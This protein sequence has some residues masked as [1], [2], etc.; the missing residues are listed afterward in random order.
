MESLNATCPR[1]TVS[2]ISMIH[3]HKLESD[4]IHLTLPYRRL[5]LFF[6][7][8]NTW[9]QIYRLQLNCEFEVPKD[10][11]HYIENFII[12]SYKTLKVSKL[13]SPQINL[14]TTKIILFISKLIRCNFWWQKFIF[15]VQ[16]RDTTS[17]S[18]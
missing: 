18:A 17:N 12:D 9:V 6:S 14:W 13:I 3:F 10:W 1:L 11:L 15:S 16:K 2:N 7:Y 8:R 5:F 4:E